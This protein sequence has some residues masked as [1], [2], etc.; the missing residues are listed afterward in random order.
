MTE[1]NFLSVARARS[2]DEQNKNT[3]ETFKTISNYFFSSADAKPTLAH[4]GLALIIN[5][6]SQNP[7]L[8]QEFKIY[9]SSYRSFICVFV[10][11]FN[12]KGINYSTYIEGNVIKISQC[13]A[14]TVK[15]LQ[16]KQSCALS[17]YLFFLVNSVCML[18]VKM[19]KKKNERRKMKEIEMCA[20]CILSL[21]LSLS[22]LNTAT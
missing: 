21:F 7:F 16:V 13:D 19:L 4:R 3:N 17:I 18:N 14:N 9:F 1:K 6:F 20:Y 5:E 2:L 15:M 11:F 22:D 8:Y 12:L 10:F